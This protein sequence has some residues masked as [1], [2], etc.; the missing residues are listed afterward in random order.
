MYLSK[1][2]RVAVVILVLAPTYAVAADKFAVELATPP[3]WFF[4]SFD[5]FS[6]E[7]TCTAVNLHDEPITLTTRL[8]FHDDDDL[9]F[10]IIP[11]T[12]SG[13][14][15]EQVLNPGE[16]TALSNGRSSDALLARCVFQYEGHPLRVKASIIL[17][18]FTSGRA[19][20]AAAERVRAERVRKKR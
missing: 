11:D 19:L 14:E 20:T 6:G 7:A 4:Q 1:V 12:L 16:A 10:P 8:I 18:D 13:E 2:A 15:V 3:I 5:S 17:E 9:P